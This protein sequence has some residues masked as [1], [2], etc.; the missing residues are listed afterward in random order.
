MLA[1]GMPKSSQRNARIHPC[2]ASEAKEI[3]NLSARLRS[4]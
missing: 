1:Q 3:G 4:C 2:T